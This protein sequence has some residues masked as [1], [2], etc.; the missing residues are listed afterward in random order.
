MIVTFGIWMYMCLELS[1]DVW[2]CNHVDRESLDFGLSHINTTPSTLRA[3]LQLPASSFSFS[4]QPAM[5]CFD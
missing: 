3:V 1:K 2:L 4:V 5:F